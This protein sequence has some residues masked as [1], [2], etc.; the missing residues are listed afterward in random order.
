MHPKSSIIFETQFSRITYWIPFSSRSPR[1]PLIIV[2]QLAAAIWEMIIAHDLLAAHIAEDG[3]TDTSDLV[4]AR[5]LLNGSFAIWTL[6]ELLQNVVASSC[7]SLAAQGQ[8]ELAIACV[9]ALQVLWSHFHQFFGCYL[10]VFYFFC[11]LLEL[12]L[13]RS[14][15]YCEHFIII[16][17]VYNPCKLHCEQT[18]TLFY[19]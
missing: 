13:T 2:P 17:L 6:W 12:V 14:L 19:I 18:K 9:Q 5:R 10:K 7:Q 1:D 16:D 4:A 8:Q 11:D 3:A 15:F